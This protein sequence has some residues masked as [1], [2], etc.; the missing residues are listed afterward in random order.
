MCAGAVP[1][2][3]SDSFTYDT[4][5]CVEPGD[6]RSSRYH[7]TLGVINLVLIPLVYFNRTWIY[8]AFSAAVR[9]REKTKDMQALGTLFSTGGKDPAAFTAEVGGPSHLHLHFSFLISISI[10]MLSC[11]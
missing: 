11:A 3:C 4:Y 7:V 6:T 8:G 10:S 5:A 2:D 9:S 1:R